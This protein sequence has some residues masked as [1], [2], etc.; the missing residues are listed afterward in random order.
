M[1]D[2]NKSGIRQSYIKELD[3]LVGYEMENQVLLD[4][5]V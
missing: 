1:A 3:D 2:N 5:Y 4:E